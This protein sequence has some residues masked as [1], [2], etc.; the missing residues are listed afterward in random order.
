MNMS[1]DIRGIKINLIYIVH[2][3]TKIY[4]KILHNNIMYKLLLIVRMKSTFHYDLFD[5][6][7]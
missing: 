1:S 4:N 7:L 6:K 3:Y 2:V 5:P